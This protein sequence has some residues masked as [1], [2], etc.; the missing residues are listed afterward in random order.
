MYEY[1]SEFERWKNFNKTYN[2]KFSKIKVLSI[3]IIGIC[4]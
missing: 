1:L 4:R 2:E 3:L